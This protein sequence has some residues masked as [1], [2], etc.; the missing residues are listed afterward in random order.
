MAKSKAPQHNNREASAS[1]ATAIGNSSVKAPQTGDEYL[2][3]AA[4]RP[5]G[6]HLRRAGQGRHHAS[7]LPQHRAH[8]GAAL[9]RAARPQAQGQD[10]AADRHR[11]RRHDARLLQGAEDAGRP[12]RRPRRHRRMGASSPTAGWAARPTT[13]RRSWPRSAPMPTSTIPT[14]TTR[15]AGTS[16]ARSA[17]P[18][19]T[20]PS[21]IRRSIATGRRTR[22]ATSAAT[23]RR[24]PT[25]ASSCPAPRWWR[26][27]RC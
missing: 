27:A 7:G 11:Q 9:R 14:R 8:G 12:D 2:A 3:L 13:R 18:S 21:S 24:R 5:R 26:P 23:S 1:K 25:P 6:L 20:T 15:G 22:S 10:P 19:S 16:S 4:R 17:C